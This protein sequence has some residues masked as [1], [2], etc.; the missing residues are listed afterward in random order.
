[1][2]KVDLRSDTVT[3]PTEK[4]IKAMATAPLGDDVYGEDPT[5]NLL[6]STVA[7]ATG[8]EAAIFTV[9]GTMGNQLAIMA[10]VNRGDEIICEE[11]A[12]V[13]MYEGA[14]IAGL[15]GA[16]ARTV[17]A[18]DGILTPELVKEYIRPNN[19]V[20][21]PFT[22][23]ICLENTHNHAGGT[24]Y[25]IEQLKTMKDFADSVNVKV[26]MDG[27]RVMNAAVALGVGI[28]EITKYVDSISICLSKALG[29]PV[30]AIVA[31]SNEY[32]ARVRRHRKSIGGGMR[33][34]GVLAAAGLIAFNEMPEVLVDD[35]KRAKKLAEGCKEIGFDINIDD[36][37]TNIVI[38]ASKNNLQIVEEL[39]KVGVLCN[40]FGA[41]R[42]RFVTHYNVDDKGVDCALSEL[43]K[44]KHLI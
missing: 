26:H 31:G 28:G 11:K 42:F 23:A 6:E 43:R 13:F 3:L 7:K 39:K 5:I 8:K 14:G 34:A 24:Y 15:S 19:D 38:L 25:T 30:G 4:M 20:H 35:H 9:S 37:K 16:Q 29:A 18:V 22:K 41:G 21:Q 32:I 33:Q 27:A 44:L 40:P 10:H 17:K 2:E 12:H 36:V 1:M